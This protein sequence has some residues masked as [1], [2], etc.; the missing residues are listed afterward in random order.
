MTLRGKV[1]RLAM[2]MLG[3]R[4]GNTTCGVVAAGRLITSDP[5]KVTCGRCRLVERMRRKRE[6]KR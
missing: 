1:H 4:S 2:D 6:A 3:R 5:K